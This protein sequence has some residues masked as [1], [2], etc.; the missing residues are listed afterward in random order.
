MPPNLSP[1]SLP[2]SSILENVMVGARD[3]EHDVVMNVATKLLVILKV[4][5]T[6]PHQ[7]LRLTLPLM[8]TIYRIVVNTRNWVGGVKRNSNEPVP[9]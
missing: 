2:N 5:S 9:S 4:C 3:N 7:S 8:L 1:R 6:I